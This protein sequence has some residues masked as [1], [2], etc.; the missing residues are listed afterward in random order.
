MSGYAIGM[1]SINRTR[2][3]SIWPVQVRQDGYQWRIHPHGRVCIPA[4][5]GKRGQLVQDGVQVVRPAG[6][7]TLHTHTQWVRA[8]NVGEQ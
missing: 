3:T 2:C 6:A 5:C 4:L 1:L 7:H 8:R